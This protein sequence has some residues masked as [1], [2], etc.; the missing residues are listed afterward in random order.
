MTQQRLR[1][2]TKFHVSG[3]VAELGLEFV[4]RSVDND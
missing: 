2:L 3:G 1:E 4:T